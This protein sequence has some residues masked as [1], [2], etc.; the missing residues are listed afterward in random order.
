MRACASVVRW[1]AIEW[2]C[3]HIQNWYTL[4]WQKSWLPWTF[5]GSLGCASRC[6]RIIS[7]VSTGIAYAIRHA[8]SPALITYFVVACKS[9]F[10]HFNAACH[11]RASIRNSLIRDIMMRLHTY[12]RTAFVWLLFDRRDRASSVVHSETGSQSCCLANRAPHHTCMCAPRWQCLSAVHAFVASAID[13]RARYLNPTVAC[14]VLR[15]T[16]TAM[17]AAR[18]IQPLFDQSERALSVVLAVRCNAL[19][20]S[21]TD[22]RARCL[23]AVQPLLDTAQDSQHVTCSS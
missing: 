16:A 9:F 18:F 14:A 17:V 2:Q 4:W 22:P 12:D 13:Q 11:A 3:T 5:E 1:R 7:S 20:A 15:R 21:A 19:A 6:S 10:V 8:E 23:A